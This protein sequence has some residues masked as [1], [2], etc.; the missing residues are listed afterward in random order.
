MFF[1]FKITTFESDWSG[2]TDEC[3]ALQIVES[4]PS[5]TLYRTDFYTDRGPICKLLFTKMDGEIIT[6][7]IDDFNLL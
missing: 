6:E 5:C 4:L 1:T 7:E 2:I 3:T